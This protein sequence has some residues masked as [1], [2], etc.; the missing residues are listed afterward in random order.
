MFEQRLIAEKLFNIYKTILFLKRR[1]RLIVNRETRPVRRFHSYSIGFDRI[2]GEPPQNAK[3]QIV[4]GA[5][6]PGVGV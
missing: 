6:V 2:A 3:S 1:T 5:A 4:F